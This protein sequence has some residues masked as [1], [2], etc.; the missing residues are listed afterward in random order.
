MGSARPSCGVGYS[1]SHEND[2]L[3]HTLHASLEQTLLDKNTT[4]AV[5]YGLSLNSVGRADDV[6]FER[7]LD[8]ELDLGVVDADRDAPR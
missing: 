5:G 4:L 2:Y 7:S 3:S 6:N 8:R 1:Y